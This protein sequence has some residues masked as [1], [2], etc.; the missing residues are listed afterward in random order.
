[1]FLN[2]SRYIKVPNVQ[3]MLSDGT[4]VNAVKLRMIPTTQ[5]QPTLV[6]TNDRLDVMSERSY[7]DSARYWHIAD[8]NTE[9][10]S[11]KLLE[12]WLVGDQTAQQLSIAVPQ[13]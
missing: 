6:N 7:G 4:Q 12:Q 9:M 1:M 10:D 8:A 3:L 5:G 2:T 13:S 11:N